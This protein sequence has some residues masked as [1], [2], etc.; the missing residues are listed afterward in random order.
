MEITKI[1]I[2]SSLLN[3]MSFNLSSTYRAGSV[4]CHF[5][6]GHFD[7][8][9][10]RELFPNRGE[11]R[12]GFLPCWCPCCYIFIYC[13]F[14]CFDCPG[15]ETLERGIAVFEQFSQSHYLDRI[16][17]RSLVSGYC[18]A[19]LRLFFLLRCRFLQ[20]WLEFLLPDASVIIGL[21]GLECIKESLRHFFLT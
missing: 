14:G 3:F 19:G 2:L 7:Q 20:L 1:P 12:R 16:V 13:T 17:C 15:P 4:P 21:V 5:V 10:F 9:C 18:S 11:R 8:E 6:S